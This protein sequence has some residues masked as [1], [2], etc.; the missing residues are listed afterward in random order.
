M[1]L[2]L[3]YSPLYD[4]LASPVGLAVPQMNIW[5]LFGAL[6]LANVAMWT[7]YSAPLLVPIVCV[8]IATLALFP[9]IKFMMPDLW[10]TMENDVYSRKRALWLIPITACVMYFLVFSRTQAS[11]ALGFLGALVVLV[12]IATSPYEA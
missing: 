10:A 5:W 9:T 4:S 1:S 3:R 12:Q 2:S 8:Q 7:Y 6:L 11:N